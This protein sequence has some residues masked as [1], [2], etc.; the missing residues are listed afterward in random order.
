M[1]SNGN[2]AINFDF[3]QRGSA[4]L[5]QR[6][7][8]DLTTVPKLAARL[9]KEPV[10]HPELSPSDWVPVCEESL[11]ALDRFL[12]YAKG[13]SAQTDGGPAVAEARR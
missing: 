7:L 10:G 9:P 5:A 8:S 4:D 3:V 1:R 13:R 6:L 12:T 2:I 11:A